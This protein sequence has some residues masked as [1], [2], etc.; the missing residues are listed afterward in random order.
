MVALL[1]QRQSTYLPVDRAPSSSESRWAQQIGVTQF[2]VFPIIVAGTIVGCLYVDRTSSA[3]AP[4]RA[5]LEYIKS[6]CSVVVMAIDARRRN[7]SANA[8]AALPTAPVAAVGQTPLTAH[9]KSTLVLRVLRG[10]PLDTVAHTA[11]VSVAQ[12]EHWRAAFLDGATASLQ[13]D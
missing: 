13:N 8:A 7:S 12:L 6:L 1:Q 4:D 3:S 11:S 10:E 9:E 2:G 5:A